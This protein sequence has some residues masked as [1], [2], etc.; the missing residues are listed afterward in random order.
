MTRRMAAL[1]VLLAVSASATGAFAA[2]SCRPTRDGKDRVE[3]PG[4]CPSG[5][6]ARGACCESIRAMAPSAVQTACPAGMMQRLGT[7]VPR[8]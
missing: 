6:V 1:I 4:V 8:Q 7:C 5:Y 3:N 2:G